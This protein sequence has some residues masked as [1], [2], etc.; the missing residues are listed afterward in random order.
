M[1]NFGTAVGDAGKPAHSGRDSSAD[2]ARGFSASRL[3]AAIARRLSALVGTIFTGVTRPTRVR[4]AGR[5]HVLP[6]GR[7]EPL[8]SLN[9]LR[10]L[11][12]AAVGRVYSAI[13]GRVSSRRTRPFRPRTRRPRRRRLFV[14]GAVTLATL[15]LTMLPGALAATGT[16][17]TV[18]HAADLIDTNVGNGQCDTTVAGKCTLRAAIMESNATSGRDT[19]QIQ[20][21]RPTSS[22]SRRSTRTRRGS[23][24]STSRPGDDQGARR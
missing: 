23:A 19:I 8:F 9:P 6:T 24:T 7:R 22:R 13:S 17:F 16:T 11:L 5:I 10:S 4:G 15:T 3:V 12:K 14:A 1:G 20:P 18:N 21:G 2:D